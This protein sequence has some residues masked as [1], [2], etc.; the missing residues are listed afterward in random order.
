MRCLVEG[1]KRKAKLSGL[2][3]YPSPEG[4]GLLPRH[5]AA[6][7]VVRAAPYAVKEADRRA[8]ASESINVRR[9]KRLRAQL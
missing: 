7:G 4:G 6:P 9:C 8:G 2:L 3:P 1:K 5:D